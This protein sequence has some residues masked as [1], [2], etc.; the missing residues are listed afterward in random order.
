MKRI[1]LSF[2][3]ISAIMACSMVACS[4]REAMWEQS[5]SPVTTPILGLRSHVAL[6]DAP[7]ERV[8]FLGAEDATTLTFT[9]T[10]LDRGL[11]AW[12][13]T[14][15]GDRLLALTRGDVPRRKATDQTPALTVYS[16]G[17]GEGAAKRYAL[18]DPLD[19]LAIDPES[20]VAV[21][22]AT[23][24]TG[25]FVQNP[26]ELVLVRL[27]EPPSDIN[28]LPTTIRSFG[29]RPEGFMFTAPLSL[30]DGE[31]RLLAVRTDRD[32][33][34]LD[35]GAPEKPE[36][37]VKLGSGAAKRHPVGFAVTDG[38]PDDETDARIAVRIEND[39]SVVLLDLKPTPEE[40]SS[41][42]AFSPVPNLV[43]VG[44][45][46]GD[47]V[48]GRTDAGL[49]LIA[50]VPSRQAIALVEPTT[51]VATEVGIGASFDRIRL[52]TDVVGTAGENS[53]VALLWSG[54]T[55][56]VAFVAMGGAIGK[57]YKSVERISIGAPV[58][59]VV[60]VPA[61]H[62]HMLIL[63]LQGGGAL[64]A[65][66]LV[67]RTISPLVTQGAQ[68]SAVA[69]A[70]GGRLWV[71]SPTYAGLAVVGLDTLHP[72][73]L[74]LGFPVTGAYDI[75]RKDAGRALLAWHGA[76]SGAVSVFDAQD[77]SLSNYSE[78]LGILLGDYGEAR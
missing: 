68:A 14:Q 36:I 67:E 32:V 39:S 75:E 21:L 56:E 51:G 4:G 60:D 27:G 7:A 15:D 78:Y 44:G 77:P 23:G 30:S 76:G 25:A 13:Q 19:G 5:A 48:F 38:E 59:A 49:R 40:S 28:P 45:V 3:V 73:N 63:A 52:V 43:D 33:A 8:V 64:L 31:H 24:Q 42:H 65:L 26:N 34:L 22:F 2:G 57:P 53:D 10:P 70:D 72:V 54:S 62:E 37:T 58:A 46:P 50:T 66:D 18:A 47:I 61:P 71:Y 1:Y 12:G 11:A 41:P 29:G 20:E 6:L 17:E 74:N 9:E 16:P 35:I 55:S 69:S